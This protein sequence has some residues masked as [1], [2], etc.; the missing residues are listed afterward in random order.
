MFLTA[1]TELRD[2]N[3]QIS[4]AHMVLLL[5]TKQRLEE[6]RNGRGEEKSMTMN[7]SGLGLV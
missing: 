4:C 1:A 5:I 3:L 7:I 2:H 6:K